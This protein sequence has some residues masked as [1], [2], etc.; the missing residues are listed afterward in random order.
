MADKTR[1]DL[2][3]IIGE[4]RVESVSVPDVKPMIEP[5]M[6]CT[7]GGWVWYC[8][9]HDTHGNADI[10]DEAVFMADMHVMFWDEHSVAPADDCETVVRRVVTV[11][12]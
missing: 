12:G 5:V 2:T 4:G 7:T 10:E 11:D 8:D 6:G 9:E 3:L 1:P